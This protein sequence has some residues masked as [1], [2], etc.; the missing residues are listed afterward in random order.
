[1]LN[2]I[3]F[4]AIVIVI[5]FIISSVLY[6][7]IVRIESN[8]QVI[9]THEKIKNWKQSQNK[10]RMSQSDKLFTEEGITTES[11]PSPTDDQ[12]PEKS[13]SE[14]DISPV[15]FSK[16]FGIEADFFDEPFAEETQPL[17]DSP[18]GYGAY[19]EV[20]TDYPT[21]FAWQG[22]IEL[23]ETDAATAANVETLHRV[24]FKLW[25]EGKRATGG[26]IQNGRVYPAFPK[27]G[28]VEWS[29]RVT[30][31]GEVIKYASALTTFKDTPDPLPENRLLQKHQ[32]PGYITLIPFS[33]GGYD[34][35]TFL[36]E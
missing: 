19:P 11:M 35:S 9:A 34:P 1:M 23:Y 4:S 13:E 17:P 5:L 33:E 18:L 12:T 30:P 32:V 14:V 22:V 24:L 6:S 3:Y 2:R 28:Y 8:K 21:D 26:I 25:A 16:P 10:E 29:E 31:S 20:P 36:S 27:T 7:Y 15:D